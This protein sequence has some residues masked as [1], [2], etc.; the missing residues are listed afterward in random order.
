[1]L[2]ACLCFSLVSASLFDTALA[3]PPWQKS[4]AAADALPVVE[5]TADNTLLDQSCIVR[6]APNL[7]I[8]DLDGNGVLHVVADE[9]QI[10]FEEG[11]VL[12]GAA[13]GTPGDTL[14]GIGV[15]VDG[16]SKVTL[17]DME[18]SGFRCGILVTESF[19]LKVHDVYLHHNFRQRLKST[20]AAEDPGDWLWPHDNNQQQWRKNYGAGLCV[21]RSRFAEILRVKVREQQNG[22][23]LDGV[24]LSS[25]RDSDCSFLSGW[26]LAMWRSC[27]NKVIHNA[28]DFCI[29]GYSHGVYNRGQDSAG[30]L[31]FEQCTNNAILR[32]SVTHGGDGIFAFSGKEALGET[33]APTEDFS[34]ERRG[35]NFN[36]FSNNHLSFAAAHGLELTF[37]FNNEI[38]R[39]V[40]EG[41]AICGFWGGYS[42]HTSITSNLFRANGDAGYGLERG[43]INID[44]SRENRIVSNRMEGNACGVHLWDFPSGLT[45]TPWGVANCA[46]SEHNL[47]EF[48][49]MRDQEVDIQLRGIAHA[50]IAENSTA[51]GI[52][53]SVDIGKE[54][55]LGHAIVCFEEIPGL[56]RRNPDLPDS[57]FLDP[58][59]MNLG[60]REAIIMTE[61]GP[62]DHQAP[63]LR[64]AGGSGTRHEYEMLPLG[65]KVQYS[66]GDPGGAKSFGLQLQVKDGRASVIFGADGYA[67]YELIAQTTTDEFRTG[68]WFMNTDWQVQVFKSPCDPREDFATWRAAVNG[69]SSTTF[70]TKQLNLIYGM[71]GPA[72]LPELK[73]QEVELGNEGFGTI[74]TTTA[75]LYPGMWLFK[76]RSD[77][78]VRILVDGKV[79]LE[80]WTWHGPTVNEAVLEVVGSE[81]KEIVVEHFELD[82]YATLE[83]QISPI[84]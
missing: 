63:L 82:G 53:L 10:Y 9:V 81:P 22:I 80:N 52:E 6:I 30:I 41:N 79:L 83:L 33:P 67:E 47:I 13:D 69:E 55:S 60:G 54:A 78:G 4:S 46:P 40:L 42:Q 5:V 7:V 32:N 26:G 57:I 49:S 3:P 70:T 16:H 12:R 24:H 29:R 48:N 65:T 51:E 61:W 73:N 84:S 23:I 75:K 59:M 44:H 21:E 14:T 64:K 72:N 71:Q 74:A 76:M 1:M 50:S 19:D 38:S 8:A 35:N 18:I 68:G 37:G 28:F 2:F 11:T 31:M 77:D 25:V 17:G 62:W 43:A 15:R 45:E 58:S 27:D 39:N 56:K 66:F 34:Y 20:P 36:V